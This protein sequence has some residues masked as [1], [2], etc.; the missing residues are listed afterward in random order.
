MFWN[1]QNGSVS[2][3]DTDMDY[4]SFGKGRDAFRF[5]LVV[6][7]AL[8]LAPFLLSL[9]YLCFGT[10]FQRRVFLESKIF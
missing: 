10:R 2:I 9:F 3:G 6:L 7:C 1:A 4:V 8:L 5:L